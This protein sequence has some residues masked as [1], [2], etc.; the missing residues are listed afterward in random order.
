MMLFFVK[1]LGWSW[2]VLGSWGVLFPKSAR[3]RLEKRFKRGVRKLFFV[4][5]AAITGFL[6]VVGQNV[7]GVL[8]WL[9]PSAGVATAVQ[10]LL[11][12]RGQLTE[13]FVQWWLRQPNW[14][15]R[16][17]AAGFGVVGYAM[18][19]LSQRPE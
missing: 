16:S 5:A 15:Y 3:R 12:L 6:F 1:L 2:V 8:S 17:T 10:G 11:F 4:I 13:R 14:V 18:Q 9:L 19:W 7:D